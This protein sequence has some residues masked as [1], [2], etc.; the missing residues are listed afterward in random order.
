MRALVTGG[1]GLIG[2]TLVDLLLAEGWQLTILDNL[3]PQTHLRGK[4]PW[5]PEAA[6]FIRGSVAEPADVRA[7][8]EGVNVVF[9]QAAYGGY[10]PQIAKYFH[11]NSFGTALLLEMIQEERF[12]VEKVVVAS[13]QAVY[14]EGKAECPSHGPCYPRTRPEEQLARR[15]WHV[16]CPTCAQP[17]RSIPTDEEAPVGGGAVYAQTKHDEERLA[18]W[19]GQTYGVPVVA[20]RYSCTYG[21][22]Q[23][24]FNPYTGVIAIFTTRLLNDLPPVFYEDGEQTRDMVYVADV[25][26]ANLLVATHDGANGRVLNVGSGRPVSVRRMAEIIGARL[27]KPVEPVIRGEYRPGEIR[28]L[29]SDITRISALGYRPTVFPEE[30]IP[31]YLDWI[32]GQSDVRDYFS[33][34]ERLLQSK[35][36]VKQATA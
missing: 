25:A 9:H 2:S 26:R 10:M 33:E 34:A 22:R 27:G 12:P 28:S 20:L 30:G 24:I 16:L 5:V 18:L 6:R 7:A 11:V 35:R 1:A 21:P 32:A 17:M 3:E 4:P 29:I 23:S 13:S 8:L 36:Y 14:Y 19:W 15:E 31:R